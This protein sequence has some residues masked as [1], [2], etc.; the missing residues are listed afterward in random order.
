MWAAGF[1]LFMFGIR[2][3]VPFALFEVRAGG[4]PRPPLARRGAERALGI[5]LDALQQ[6]AKKKCSRK[7]HP[8]TSIG[9]NPVAIRNRPPRAAVAR[10]PATPS[11]QCG[12][13]ALAVTSVRVG[14]DQFSRSAE[15]WRARTAGRREASLRG[16]APAPNGAPRLR[17]NRCRARI[18]PPSRRRVRLDTAPGR[19]TFRC[20]RSRGPRAR[21]AIAAAD[22]AGFRALLLL[23]D[24]SPVSFDAPTP[25]S[26]FARQRHL[27]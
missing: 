10:R 15:T 11:K 23:R 13:P 12:W 19:V 26:C 5:R 17:N 6:P 1:A 8:G 24:A 18:E 4:A 7:R 14:C 3:F 20:N 16:G 21:P 27:G 25:A 2:A 22:A 9:A